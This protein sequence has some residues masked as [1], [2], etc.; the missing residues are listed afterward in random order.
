[1]KYLTANYEIRGVAPL[2]MHN[3]RLADP[4]SEMAK[5]MKKVSGKRDKTDADHAELA[6]LEWYGSLYL[7]DG[8]PCIPGE[9]VEA[10]LLEAAKKRKKGQQAKAGIL[11]EKN[12]HLVYDGPK[13]IDE[14]WE[15]GKYRLSAGVKIQRNRIIRTRPR[16]LEW[17]AKIEVTYLDS[18]LNER[19]V[20]DFLD[21]GGMIIGLGDWR[22]RFG[23]FEVVS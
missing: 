9:L 5:A 4:L 11:C 8:A 20:R 14:L 2:L 3:G 17:A 21:I 18:L 7:H 16:F 15:S 6:R 1:M 12:F 23:R 22:P 13:D 10:M 19:D